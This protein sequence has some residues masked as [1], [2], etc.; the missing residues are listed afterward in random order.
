MKNMLFGVIFGISVATM[1]TLPS[2]W[3]QSDPVI[4]T[5]DGAIAGGTPVDFTRAE[6]EA[7]GSATIATTTPWSDGTTTFEG[8][9][10]SALLAHIGATGETADVLALNNYRTSVP[11]ADFSAYP[12]I[13][14]LKK[15]GEYMAVRDKGP[16]F[17]IYPFDDFEELRADIYYSRSAWQVRSMTIK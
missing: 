5:I 4:L 2:A 17:I 10:M 3:A 9:P 13:L 1:G 7:I 12:V 6:L 11:V 14:A 16:L 8:V 15:N